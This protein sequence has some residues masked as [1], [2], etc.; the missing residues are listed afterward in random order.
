MTD[1]LHQL[2]FHKEISYSLKLVLQYYLNNHA[3]VVHFKMSES[4]VE[5]LVVV[6]YRGVEIILRCYNKLFFSVLDS[7]MGQSLSVNK[8]AMYELFE[9]FSVPSPTTWSLSEK[10]TDML[11]SLK[12][13][14]DTKYV[15]KPQLGSHGDGITTG[16]TNEKSLRQAIGYARQFD[17]NVIVQ[18]QVEGNE[19]R[20]L[21]VDFELVAATQRHRPYIIGDGRSTVEELLAQE[22]AR[23]IQEL[24][25]KSTYDWQAVHLSVSGFSTKDELERVKG[26]VFLKSVITYGERIQL[27][28]KANIGLG[29]ISEDVTNKVNLNVASTFSKLFAVL[30]LPFCGVD[31]ISEDIRA[32]IKEHKTQT[33]EINTRPGLLMHQQPRLGE[34]RDVGKVVSEAIYQRHKL[35]QKQ[36]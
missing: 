34:R 14:K 8:K 12:F 23:R 3:R 7:Y 20:L 27:S 36:M 9:L 15:V 4:P 18:R 33:I 32:S 21:Y 1:N 10:G 25:E 16:I 29:G 6:E 5:A 28:E 2:F 22:N 13:E 30:D 11:P 35:L 24:T 17:E 26:K 19:Y 31:I